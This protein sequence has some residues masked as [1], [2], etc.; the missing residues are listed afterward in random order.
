MRPIWI[1]FA[2]A[3]ALS[4]CKAEPTPAEKAAADAHAIAQVEAVNHSF[5][6]LQPLHP[7]PL[8][9]AE[10]ERHGLLGAGCAF[11][12]DGQADPVLV[13]RRKRAAMKFGR[14][15]TNY[16]SDPGSPP[17]ALGTW[18]HYVGKANSLR[19]VT[20]GGSD[21]GSQTGLEWPATLTVTDAHDRMV[22][23]SR[24]KLRCGV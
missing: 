22:Y 10:L 8:T 24:G 23:T 18:T 9:P 19:L 3:L 14:N 4:A 20:V 1:L 11:V 16:A 7:E 17:L 15:L 6:P 2:G 5:G 12:A 13:A 21:L